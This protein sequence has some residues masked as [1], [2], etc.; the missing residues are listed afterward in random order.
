MISVNSKGEYDKTSWSGSAGRNIPFFQESIYINTSLDKVDIHSNQKEK[1]DYL[2]IHETVHS[3]QYFDDLWNKAVI[4]DSQIAILEGVTEVETVDRLKAQGENIW[5]EN[6]IKRKLTTQYKGYQYLIREALENNSPG[7]K[8]FEQADYRFLLEDPIKAEIFL[9]EALF[10]KIQK[11]TPLKTKARAGT[12]ERLREHS[13]QVLRLNQL[14]QNINNK[15]DELNLVE[16]KP[17]S[18]QA[19]IRKEVAELKRLNRAELEAFLEGIS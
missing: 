15:T 8:E 10:G 17:E 5:F 3:T 11:E 13:V 6:K 16:D 2:L 14:I 1:L 4:S 9:A 7:K 12:K 19:W 18:V